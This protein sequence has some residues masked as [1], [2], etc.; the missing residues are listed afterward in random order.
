M[1][2]CFFTV[3][4]NSSL[5][6]VRANIF[7]ICSTASSDFIP[8]NA[9][10]IIYTASCSSFVRRRSSRLV[11]DFWISIAGNTLFSCSFLLTC[12]EWMTFG[13]DFYVNVLLCRTC[14]E[15]ITAVTGYSCLIVVRM[16]SFS[17]DFH[18]SVKILFTIRIH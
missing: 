7:R 3:C 12:V 13:A 9:L 18:L 6:L 16:D 1:N 4:T 10:R 8:F 11:P 2:F 5:F 17:H 14:Y 15:C